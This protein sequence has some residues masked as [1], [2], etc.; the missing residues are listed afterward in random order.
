MQCRIKTP[1]VTCVW[2]TFVEDVNVQLEGRV[3][4]GREELTDRQVD[5]LENAEASIKRALE[6]NPRHPVG[7]IVIGV[8]V[9]SIVGL[10]LNLIGAGPAWALWL[11]M[12]GQLYLRM[13]TLLIVPLVCVLG[14]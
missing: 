12:L 2:T 14:A 4:E 7:R 13:M 9:G 1:A 10:I 6:L 8:I 5:D 11:G 3:L